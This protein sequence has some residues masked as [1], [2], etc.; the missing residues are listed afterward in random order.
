M[1]AAAVRTTG[2]VPAWFGVG[3]SNFGGV[4][5]EERGHG[6]KKGRSVRGEACEVGWAH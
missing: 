4:S 3:I 2:G 6:K 5:V 1:D